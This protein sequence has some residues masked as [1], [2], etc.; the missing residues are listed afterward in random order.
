MSER[1][2]SATRPLEVDVDVEAERTV[3]TVTG[4]RD[5][6]VVVSSAAGERIY[7]PPAAGVDDEADPYRPGGSDSPYEGGRST[8]TP[9]GSSPRSDPSVGLNRTADGFR[10]LHPEPVHDVRLLCREDR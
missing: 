7:L 10:I 5:A 1:G 9:Y 3:V 2:D 8:Q 6:A 4:D